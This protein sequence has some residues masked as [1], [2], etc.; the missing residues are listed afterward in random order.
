MQHGWL[1]GAVQDPAPE[2]QPSKK[3]KLLS[4]AA[5]AALGRRPKTPATINAKA[6]K[7]SAPKAKAERKAVSQARPKAKAAAEPAVGPVH[8]L[9]LP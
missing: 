9:F 3:R 2:A 8:L 1:V 7:I 5:T 6:T 4:K